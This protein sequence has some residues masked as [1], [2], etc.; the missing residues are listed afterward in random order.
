MAFFR[1]F[2]AFI[3]L[4]RLNLDEYRKN[5][6]LIITKIIDLLRDFYYNLID[7]NIL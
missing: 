3:L 2:N 4:L 5:L 7:Y 6:F 1:F